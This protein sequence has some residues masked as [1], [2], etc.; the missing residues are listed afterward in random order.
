MRKE[1]WKQDDK[2]RKLLTMYKVLHMR[3]KIDKLDMKR[4]HE[5]RQLV[6]IKDCINSAI[7]GLEEY[8]RQQ[9]KMKIKLKQTKGLIEIQ[10]T[11]EK[12][13]NI[14]EKQWYIHL[15]R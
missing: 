15:K 2:T 5:E 3:D 6:S 12:Y 8:S 4:K 1:H 11:T 7:K 14:A 13:S 9:I 10:K